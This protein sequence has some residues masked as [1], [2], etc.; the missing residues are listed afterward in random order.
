[1][2]HGMPSYKKS[3]AV[4]VAF[5]TKELHRIVR[6]SKGCNGSAFSMISGTILQRRKCPRT[7]PARERP[8]RQEDAH[9]GDSAS[10]ELTS[11]PNALPGEAVIGLPLIARRA[12]PNTRLA[13]SRHGLQP[14][15]SSNCRRFSVARISGTLPEPDLR[16]LE[17]CTRMRWSAASLA[18]APHRDGNERSSAR[19]RRP[20]A[21][22]SSSRAPW[23][24]SSLSVP[25]AFSYSA[26]ARSSS[27]ISRAR[28]AVSS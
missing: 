16:R 11:S 18:A 13:R 24:R 28:F 26:R 14:P 25:R 27:P 3:G 12:L 21:S 9:S 4:E 15:A 23:S 1:M 19:M 8:R 6:P 22:S 10:M 20:R 7:R 5:C 2:E 17:T